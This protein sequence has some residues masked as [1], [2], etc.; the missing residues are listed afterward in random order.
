[1]KKREKFPNIFLKGSNRQKIVLM[2]DQRIL[3]LR[4]TFKS[5]LVFKNYGVCRVVQEEPGFCQMPSISRHSCARK[6]KKKCR[7]LC[8]VQCRLPS[9]AK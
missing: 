5:M 4:K 3:I 1:M 6:R 8:R 7:V 2:G 9:Y